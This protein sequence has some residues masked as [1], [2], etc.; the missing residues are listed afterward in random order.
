MTTPKSP[1]NPFAEF[2]LR[3]DV[4][5]RKKDLFKLVTALAGC[6]SLVVEQFDQLPPGTA[7]TKDHLKSLLRSCA[8]VWIQEHPDLS[9]S[10]RGKLWATVEH[11]LLASETPDST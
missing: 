4:S 10:V 3:D 5:E 6:V 7:A 8:E 1:D 11:I 2:D 9:T